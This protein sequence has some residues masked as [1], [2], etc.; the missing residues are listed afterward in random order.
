MGSL[1]WWNA[2]LTVPAAKKHIKCGLGAHAARV[3]R[4]EC[5]PPIGAGKPVKGLERG[6]EWFEWVGIGQKGVVAGCGGGQIK[7][8]RKVG[9]EVACMLNPDPFPALICLHRLT[10]TCIRD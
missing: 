3:H 1:C 10:W 7:P 9:S 8:G 6:G 4:K 2:C 5:W